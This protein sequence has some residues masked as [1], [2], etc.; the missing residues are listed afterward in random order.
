MIHVELI[1]K[2]RS[3]KR[4]YIIGNGGSFANA[5]HIQNDLEN[6]GVR[7]HTMNPA[8]LTA[9]ANDE[10]YEFVF[11]KWIILHGEPG[12][13]LIALSGSG[14]SKNILR[15]I[16]S[17]QSIGMQTHLQ[18]DYLRSM[19]MQ[20]SEEEQVR[21]GHDLMRELRCTRY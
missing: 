15:A 19:S 9:T 13:L 2:V 3:A 12:D 1:E 5:Q 21:L 17:A 16:E 4:V 20:E 18:T 7:A 14:T 8:T 6:C 11:S 10:A